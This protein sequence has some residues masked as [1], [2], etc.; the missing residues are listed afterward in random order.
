[1]TD[2][3]DYKKL[4]KLSEAD[5]DVPLYKK[6]IKLQEEC[7]EV[8]QEFLA[9]DDKQNGI[10]TN[11]SKSA[12]GTIEAVIEEVC[13]ATNVC[14]DILNA[15]EMKYPSKS[16]YIAKRF[17]E[18]LDKWECKIQPKLDSIEFWKLYNKVNGEKNEKDIMEHMN[19]IIREDMRTINFLNKDKK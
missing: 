18:K 14:I 10:K 2:F 1:M 13:D 9:W 5:K 7:G 15:I 4:E 19:N 8:A 17:Q 12:A 16:E 11:S 6:I 3:I